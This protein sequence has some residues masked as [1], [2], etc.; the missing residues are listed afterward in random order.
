MRCLLCE[1]L[2]FTHIC[3][4]CQDIYLKPQIFKRKISHN[5]EVI[6]FYKYSEIKN[7]LHTK[8]TDLG[9]YIYNILA[10]NSMAKFAIEFNIENPI[11]SIA[12]DDNIKS[13]YSHTAILNN[14]L[15]SKFIKP[16]PFK[17][18]AKNNISYSGKSREFRLLNPRNFELKDFKGEDVILVDDLIT[19]GSTLTQAIEVLEK[20]DKIVLFC[21]TLADASLR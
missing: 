4:S 5:I 19:T 18:R 14:S 8:H 15:K 7:L 6:S 20:K 11:V 9:F 3:K 1:N 2:S 17:L 12:I 16:L 21:L 10:K 13:G